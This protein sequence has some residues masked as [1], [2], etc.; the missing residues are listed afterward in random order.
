[1][2]KFYMDAH[3]HFDLYKDKKRILNYIDQIKSYTIAVTNLPDIY[4]QY[5][6]FDEKY[7]YTQIALGYHPGLVKDFPGQIEIFKRML[8][9]TRYVGEIGIDGTIKDKEIFLRQENVFNEILRASSGNDK[10]LSV[11]SRCASKEVL[12]HLKGFEGVVIL[13]WFSGRIQ[14]LEEASAR[15]YFFSINPQMLKSKAGRAIVSHIPVH[16]I[17][18]ESDAP[19]IAELKN[20][21][22]VEFN[23][24]LY[25]YLSD[26][27]GVSNELV[28][29]RV[30]ANF[31]EV[32]KQVDKS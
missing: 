31:A 16:R 18:L 11:H 3:M 20:G 8:P 27:Y 32:I 17:L 10:I 29:M 26:I 4:R 7:R 23:D 9:F 28:M 1:M 12:S 24:A 2:N 14:D 21:Y 25:K 15:G 22:S 30:K 19:F 13:H 5:I 6:G